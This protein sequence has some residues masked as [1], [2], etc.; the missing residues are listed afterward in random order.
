MNFNILE[1]STTWKMSQRIYAKGSININ[2]TASTAAQFIHSILKIWTK[3]RFNTYLFRIYAVAMKA[4]QGFVSTLASLASLS[5]SLACAVKKSKFWWDWNLDW[6]KYMY[7]FWSLFILLSDCT[8]FGI[9]MDRSCWAWSLY[10]GLLSKERS[11]SSFL[12]CTHAKSSFERDHSSIGR[13]LQHR[14]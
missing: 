9:G 12:S 6:K 3:N 2:K 7:Y 10:P 1:T 4:K 13:T 8:F 14:L 11:H 5:P